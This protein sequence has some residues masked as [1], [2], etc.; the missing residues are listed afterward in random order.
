MRIG[1]SL[2]PGPGLHEYCR[3]NPWLNLYGSGYRVTAAALPGR[4]S[5]LQ[6]LS[7]SPMRVALFRK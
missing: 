5:V 6:E 4:P 2:Y 3:D 7:I 1:D